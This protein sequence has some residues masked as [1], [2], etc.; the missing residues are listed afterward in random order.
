MHS[1]LQIQGTVCLSADYLSPNCVLVSPRLYY[2]KNDW[3]A[4]L[5]LLIFG[6]CRGKKQLRMQYHVPVAFL[7]TRLPEKV[8]I[9]RI[10]DAVLVLVCSELLPAQ[11]LIDWSPA[12]WQL[13]PARWRLLC[14]A[15]WR[16]FCP[17]RWRI[18]PG[19]PRGR[20]SRPRASATLGERRTQSFQERQGE[21][22]IILT[23]RW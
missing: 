18:L 11:W 8:S 6:Y 13:C 9:H 14:P 2:E 12:R 16:L 3:L 5:L 19:A 10:I 22:G 20:R 4:A 1:T 23:L 7:A 17:A 15:R 21:V